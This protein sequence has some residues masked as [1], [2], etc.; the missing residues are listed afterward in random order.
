MA[1][2]EINLTAINQPSTA[3]VDLENKSKKRKDHLLQL[4]TVLNSLN[5]E[6]TS[7]KASTSESSPPALEEVTNPSTD[8]NQKIGDAMAKM[9][10]ALQMLEILLAQF[11]KQKANNDNQIAAALITQ[12]KQILSDSQEQLK[13]LTQEQQDQKEQ[14]FWIKFAEIAVAAIITVVAIATAQPWLAVLTIAM[15]VASV[16]GGFDKLSTLISDGLKSDGVSPMWADIIA[17]AIVLVA[18]LIVTAGLSPGTAATAVAKDAETAGVEMVDMSAGAAAEASTTATEAANTAAEGSGFMSKLSY[19]NGKINPLSWNTRATMM[20]MNGMQA[21]SQMN[22]AQ[23]VEDAPNVS[24]DKKKE[25]EKYLTIILAIVTILVSIAGAAGM[26]S[27]ASS[28]RM[29]GSE[30]GILRPLINFMK[31]LVGDAQ[32]MS[33]LESLRL[34]LV[35]GSAVTQVEEGA[36]LIQQGTTQAALAQ[37]NALSDLNGTTL[38]MSNVA[39]ADSQRFEMTSQK[40][41]ASADADSVKSLGEGEQAFSELLTQYSPV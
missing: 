19:W 33:A 26:S 4:A 32:T 25:I 28:G 30:N 40:Q 2:K 37:D 39:T 1:A 11:S 15:T 24:P 5:G 31:T 35:A 6:L 41:H 27:L 38:Q 13:K 10:L 20:V 16:T 21:V 7:I 34:T 36:T 22:V 14:D 12:A 23:I 18:V 9:M 29:I 8:G 3:P 17:K